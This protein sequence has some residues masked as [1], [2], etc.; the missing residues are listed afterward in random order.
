MQRKAKTERTAPPNPTHLIPK[1]SKILLPTKDPKAMPKL[2]E[3]E[4]FD[5]ANVKQEGYSLSVKSN[6]FN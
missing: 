6:M 3:N 1:L 5:D 2:K 4:L